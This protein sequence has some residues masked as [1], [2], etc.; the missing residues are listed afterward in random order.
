MVCVYVCVF[1]VYRGTVDPA[2][3]RNQVLGLDPIL[4]TLIANISFT[5]SHNPLNKT[6]LR[7]GGPIFC[8][9]K[10]VAWSNSCPIPAHTPM[11]K[12]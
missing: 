12:I 3:T 1:A 6:I 4:G 11:V 10:I 7:P 2:A 9:H 8:P 5:I